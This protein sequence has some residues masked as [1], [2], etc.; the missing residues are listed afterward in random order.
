MTRASVLC[1]LAGL[2]LGLH[3]QSATSAASVPVYKAE[4]CC[5]LCPRAADPTAYVTRFMSGHRFMI[6]G[7]DD[8][9]FSTEVDLAT[10]FNVNEAVYAYLGRVVQAFNARG[11]QVLLLIVPQRGLMEADKLLPRDR[12]KYDF[13]AALA[14]YRAMLARFRK[15]GF[16]VPDYGVLAEKPDG[17]DYFFH[18]DNHWTPYGARRTAQVISDTVKQLPFYA[19]LRKTL[20]DTREQ[21]IERRPG[22][23]S[24]VASQICGGN[25]PAEVVKG[26]TTERAVNDA[27]GDEPLPQVALIGTSFSATPA[28]HFSGFL[29]NDLQVELLN[30]AISGGNYGGALTRYLPSETFQD[31][32]PKLLI[33]EFTQGQI[34][35]A[36]SVQLRQLVPLVDNGCANKQPLLSNNLKLASGADLTDVLFNGGGRIITAKSR[37]TMIDLQFADPS[38]E[39]ILAEAWYLDGKHELLRVRINDYTRAN[40]RFVVELNREPDFAEQP[41]VD[42]RVQVITPLPNPTSVSVKLCRSNS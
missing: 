8:W 7:K 36:N 41:L 16:I 5:R 32:P 17:T 27:F 1:V 34:A 11:T 3:S 40:G 18:R 38:V 42:F 24:L 9:L 12:A 30:A 10:T 23:L 19:S 13:N 22:M 4:P 39:E 26:Y 2:L 33:W 25:F 15:L 35:A 6:Q 37:E 21:G 20:F 14:G 31:S 29:Q 28:Y